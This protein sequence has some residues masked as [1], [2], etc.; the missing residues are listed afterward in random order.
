[1]L[2]LGA[3]TVKQERLSAKWDDN[4]H[5]IFT[6]LCVDE[7]RKGNRPST[8]LSKTGWANVHKDFN[9]ITGK[10]YVKKQLKNHWDC[11]KAEWI[12][13]DQLRQR[14]AVLGWNQKKMTIAADDAWWDAQFKV[15]SAYLQTA[16]SF[17]DNMQWFLTLAIHCLSLFN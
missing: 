1:M 14:H 3:V 16:V 17:E 7:V 2:T 10:A 4:S 9:A 5:R 11:M 13:F 6:E 12:L 15:T 8:T